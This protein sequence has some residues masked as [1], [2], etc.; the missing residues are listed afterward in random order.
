M[1]SVSMLLTRLY[2]DDVMSGIDEVVEDGDGKSKIDSV[3]GVGDV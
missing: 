3:G 1:L 2:V